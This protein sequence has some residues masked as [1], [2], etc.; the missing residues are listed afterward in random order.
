MNLDLATEISLFGRAQQFDYIFGLIHHARSNMNMM[1]ASGDR[2]RLVLLATGT[3]CCSLLNHATSPVP[4][5]K[6]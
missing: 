5:Y 6:P 1:Q 3:V 2:S 4:C